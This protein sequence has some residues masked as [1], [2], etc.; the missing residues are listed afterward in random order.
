MSPIYQVGR[1]APFVCRHIYNRSVSDRSTNYG[2][3]QLNAESSGITP[4]AAQIRQ[5]RL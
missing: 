5:L 4:A 1:G 2:G 3:R